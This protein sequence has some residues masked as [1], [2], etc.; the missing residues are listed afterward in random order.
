MYQNLGQ[1][2]NRKRP[3]LLPPPPSGPE[4]Q[5]I[6]N[7][8]SGSPRKRPCTPVSCNDETDCLPSVFANTEY[9]SP[10]RVLAPHGWSQA[11][12][13]SPSEAIKPETLSLPSSDP[14]EL[15]AGT[16]QTLADTLGHKMIHIDHQ[17]VCIGGVCRKTPRT[18]KLLGYVQCLI[19]VDYYLRG[20]CLRFTRIIFPQSRRL[21]SN[22]HFYELT[23]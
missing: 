6:A 12:S 19:F 8:D 10:P 22:L 18:P 15:E 11:W 9:L 5:Y 13:Q 4:E 14:N 17:T 20:N 1:D 21:S 3:L 16:E 23:S 7:D 2:F